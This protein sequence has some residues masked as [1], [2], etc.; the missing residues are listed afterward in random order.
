MAWRTEVRDQR[1]RQIAFGSPQRGLGVLDNLPVTAPVE[2]LIGEQRDDVAAESAVPACL[3]H[4]ECL[5]EIP[6]RDSLVVGV[7]RADAG[8]GRQPARTPVELPAGLII[9]RAPDERRGL[10]GEKLD[11]T[12]A[13]RDAASFA[14]HP[15]V[16][17]PGGL[18]LADM[19]RADLVPG[20]AGDVEVIG[21][22]LHSKTG[23]IAAA[24]CFGCAPWSEAARL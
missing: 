14:V 2:G 22:V 21:R 12:R 8:Q 7:I 1:W 6:L 11:H 10:L 3:G 9:E 13:Y 19:C 5:E 18:E 15:L 4:A 20:L 23:A 16:P 17:E 24:P